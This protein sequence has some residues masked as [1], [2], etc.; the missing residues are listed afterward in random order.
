MWEV[1]ALRDLAIKN[2]NKL[3]EVDMILLG[4]DYRVSQWFIAGCSKLI[5]RKCGPT[6]KECN[7][8]GIN[9][10][11]QIYGL[12]ERIRDQSGPG[13]SLLSPIKGTGAYQS[14]YRSLVEQFVRETFPDKIF[15]K[16][17]LQVG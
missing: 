3:H 14:H 16:K 9:F 15:E 12:R 1:T 2:M 5:T 17:G 11:V 13:P 8:L 10:V 4:I 6:E 7:R